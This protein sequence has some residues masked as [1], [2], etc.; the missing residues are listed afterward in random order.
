M[1]PERVELDEVDG[2]ATPADVCYIGQSYNLEIPIR[3]EAD[4]PGERLYRDFLAAHDR[5]YGHSVETPAK[6][7][8]IRTVHQRETAA[9]CCTKCAS[10]HRADRSKSDGAISWW[11]AQAAPMTAIV[12]DRDALREGLR[13]SGPAIVQQSDTTTLVEPGWDGLVDDAG[14]LILT[15]H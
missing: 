13:F 7:V 4:D 6:I 11:P 8:N 5:V 2:H 9:R 3:L 1:R 14:N 10:M 12:Y 15:R